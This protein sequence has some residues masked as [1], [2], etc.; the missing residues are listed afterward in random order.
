MDDHKLKIGFSMLTYSLQA[1]QNYE[2]DVDFLRKLSEVADVY[3]IVERGQEAPRVGVTKVYVQHSR[4]RS[5]LI[6]EH[7]WILLQLRLEGVRVFY[8]RNSLMNAV[9]AGL[10]TRLTGGAT[11]LWSCGEILAGRRRTRKEKGLFYFLL[12]VSAYFLA[13]RLVKG[14]VT[15][16]N[17]MRDYY[18]SELSVP[19]KKIVVLPNWVDLTRFNAG[20]AARQ[21]KRRVLNIPDDA[22]VLLFPRSLSERHGTRLLPSMLKLLRKRG[23]NAYL[24]ASGRGQYDSWLRERAVENGTAEYLRIL[25]GVP[26]REMP[27]FFAASDVSVIPS[28]TEGFPRVILESM[29]VGTP[30][31]ANA[32][33]GVTDVVSLEQKELTV[34]I[35]DLDRF[36][37]VLERLQVDPVW[38]NAMI[39]AGYKRV[40]EFDV[41]PVVAAFVRLFKTGRSSFQTMYSG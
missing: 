11:Y 26:N 37:D 25:G 19:R 4:S 27:D 9:L 3:L 17:T 23:I 31:V 40:G 5:M 32:V 13:F 6:L 41:C 8:S 21:C 39:E 12:E 28:Q 35:G 10:C 20:D 1:D 7:L 24:I 2:H 14:L 33:G 16:T 15:G 34:P 22:F 30:F 38:R 18:A 29:A 36:V